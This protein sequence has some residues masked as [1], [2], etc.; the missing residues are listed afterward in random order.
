MDLGRREAD[1]GAAPEFVAL[2][3]RGDEESPGP[4]PDL[5]VE[6]SIAAKGFERDRSTDANSSS[7][8]QRVHPPCSLCH[9]LLL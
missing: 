3:I 7:T 4:G 8:G 1:Q 9:L 2:D 5:M 6:S